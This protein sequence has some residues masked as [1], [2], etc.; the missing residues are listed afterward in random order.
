VARDDGLAPRAV[1]K[2]ARRI[3][4]PNGDLAEVRGRD[5]LG[6]LYLGHLPGRSEAQKDLI[7]VNIAHARDID[8]LTPDQASAA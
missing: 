2:L 4:D 8:L 5:G 1:K 7:E 6:D 3:L